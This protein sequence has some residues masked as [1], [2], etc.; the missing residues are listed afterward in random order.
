MQSYTFNPLFSGHPPTPP[1]YSQRSEL[2]NSR[3]NQ[4]GQGA[5]QQKR[6]IFHFSTDHA[7]VVQRVL[8][9]ADLI[10]DPCCWRP[11]SWKISIDIGNM[12]A[13]K[14]LT[15]TPLAIC[16]TA[17]LISPPLISF[18]VTSPRS[19]FCDEPCSGTQQHPQYLIR[20]T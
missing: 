8:L 15:V 1:G 12:A 9:E 19:G 7:Q 20:A 13:N 6:S 17:V 18:S 3:P 5:S 11:S 2:R 14:G 16:D 10:C 4:A